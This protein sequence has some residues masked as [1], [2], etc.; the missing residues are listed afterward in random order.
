M[1]DFKD[2]L[3]INT[4]SYK[5]TDREARRTYESFVVAQEGQ[6]LAF[7]NYLNRYINELRDKGIIS[8][9]LE[10]RA[11]IKATNSAL[12]NYEKKALDDVFG[13]EFI[14]ATDTEIQIVQ[15]ELEKILDIY[16]E[17]VHDKDNGYKAIHHSCS[18]KKEV[19]ETL[20]GIFEKQ[21]KSRKSGNVFPAIE[22]QYKTIQ[23][24]Y[25]ATY[26]TASH[27]KY[28]NTKIPQLQALYDADCLT[29][30]EYIPYM[31]VSDPNH[32]EMRELEVEEILKKMYP[33]L[34]LKKDKG[35]NEKDNRKTESCR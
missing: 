26:G 18:M 11:R 4:E 2:S 21:H 9:F 30:G 20:N 14:C 22:V 3:K 5:L 33:S 23:V 8:P 35:E 25:E 16:R 17:K 10:F 29:V 1:D 32:D 28:K 12:K 13:I 6:F 24:A 34:R 15:Q 7:I 31:W 19:I 27:E